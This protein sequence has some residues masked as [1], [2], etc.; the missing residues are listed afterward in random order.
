MGINYATTLKKFVLAF[1]L[2]N[3]RKMGLSD[4][5]HDSYGSCWFVH[6][7][8]FFSVSRPFCRFT[9]VYEGHFMLCCKEKIRAASSDSS[10][11]VLWQFFFRRRSQA[12]MISA[13][14]ICMSLRRVWHLYNICHVLEHCFGSFLLQDTFLNLQV[15]AFEGQNMTIIVNV[16]L[17]CTLYC[18]AGLGCDL[19]E[20]FACTATVDRFLSR[21][22]HL[23]SY[24]F[25]YF[26]KAYR[27][28]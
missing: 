9:L 15:F 7:P 16:L 25:L 6:L 20:L 11:I 8:F 24:V 28:V 19:I 26:E 10:Q 4:G 17:T 23:P 22:S 13:V 5:L 1:Q 2:K 3:S 21:I 18:D 12:C 14:Y 27:L